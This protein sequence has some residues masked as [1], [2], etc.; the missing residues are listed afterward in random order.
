MKSKQLLN[1]VPEKSKD[2]KDLFSI[3]LFISHILFLCSS[4]YSILY[5]I[6]NICQRSACSV[7]L[8]F[9]SDQFYLFFTSF[10]HLL[11]SFSEG[12]FCV[13]SVYEMNF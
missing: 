1:R 13:R 3:F 2:L 7:A 10:S 4:L 11:I 8:P 5:F 9:V 12:V 6:D